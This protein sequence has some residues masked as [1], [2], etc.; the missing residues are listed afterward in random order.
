MEVKLEDIFKGKQETFSYIQGLVDSKQDD[1][2]ESIC[3][4]LFVVIAK[5]D[6]K[7]EKQVID[8]FHKFALMLPFEV[9]Y[10][11]ARS[12]ARRRNN[13]IILLLGNEKLRERVLE[14]CDS[15]EAIR[16]KMKP[17]WEIENK[18]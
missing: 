9:F 11:L 12:M 18:S 14:N 5:I 6:E 7:P 4:D 3:K 15:N 1:L 17:Y 8:N 13:C 10:A 2:L 16:I